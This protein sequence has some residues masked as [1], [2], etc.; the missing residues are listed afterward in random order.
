MKWA[1]II[2]GAFILIK[3]LQVK[4]NGREPFFNTTPSIPPEGYPPGYK[5][6][7]LA[8]AIGGN[9]LSNPTPAAANPSAPTI[10]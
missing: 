3:A 7:P 4:S 10:P 2:V 5:F 6:Q 1:L 9:N 8:S